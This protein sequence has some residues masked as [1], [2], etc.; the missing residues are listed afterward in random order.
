MK[1]HYLSFQ[2]FIL[3][4]HPNQTR[5]LET[6]FHPPSFYLLCLFWTSLA[7]LMAFFVGIHHEW[8]PEVIRR[9]I[10]TALRPFHLVH[11]FNSS[12]I[13]WNSSAV[14]VSCLLVNSYIG[15]TS[16]IFLLSELG[17]LC[18]QLCVCCCHWQHLKQCPIWCTPILSVY[19]Y[20]D[21]LAKN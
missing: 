1:S 10:T 18:L 8:Y 11:S 20:N 13:C 12:N 16:T 15:S 19:N 14:N 2:C 5:Q 6:K 9:Y 4:R 17:I 3:A 21:I 7:S